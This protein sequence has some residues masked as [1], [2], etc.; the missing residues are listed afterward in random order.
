MADNIN[1]VF[2][3]IMNTV[4][5]IGDEIKT[6]DLLS[7]S[8]DL[9]FDRAWFDPG[10]KGVEGDPTSG[11]KEEVFKIDGGEVRI[12]DVP[13]D[14]L[15]RDGNLSLATVKNDETGAEERFLLTPDGTIL[16]DFDKAVLDGKNGIGG[17]GH[18]TEPV[19]IGEHIGDVFGENARGTFE[20]KLDEFARERK[21]GYTEDP[22]RTLDAVRPETGRHEFKSSDFDA[23]SPEQLE[24]EKQNTMSPRQ[25]ED[26]VVGKINE[27]K[28]YMTEKESKAVDGE[29]AGGLVKFPVD[30]DGRIKLGNYND[31]NLTDNGWRPDISTPYLNVKPVDFLSNG[32]VRTGKVDEK[33]QPIYRL[34]PAVQAISN[35]VIRKSAVETMGTAVENSVSA[36][37]DN[38]RSDYDKPTPASV[39]RSFE[40]R[41]DGVISTLNA[42][43]TDR[44]VALAGPGAKASDIEDFLSGARTP[45][46]G[47]GR[48]T[49][50]YAVYSEAVSP[51][52]EYRET[53]S[54]IAD[55]LEKC[56][57]ADIGSGPVTDEDGNLLPVSN[58]K[59]PAVI[60]SMLPEISSESM[61]G[62]REVFN[63]DG[64]ATALND[65]LEK[66]GEKMEAAGYH[67]TE[68]GVFVDEMG[69][70]PDFE[71]T[72]RERDENSPTGWNMD[73]VEEGK[74][75]ISKTCAARQAEIRSSGV[76]VST[77]T[78]YD[79]SDEAQ[80]QY[81]SAM[82]RGGR[83]QDPLAR[84]PSGDSGFV[85]FKNYEKAEKE[86]AGI[87]TDRASIEKA[88]GSYA[89]AVVR[90]VNGF[91]NAEPGVEP[92]VE[93]EGP[94]EG[95]RTGQNEY[96]AESGQPGSG[97]IDRHMDDADDGRRSY[98]YT[99]PDNVRSSKN[100]EG[101]LNFRAWKITA[102][103]HGISDAS[104]EALQNALDARNNVGGRLGF[105]GLHRYSPVFQISQLRAT[106]I[107]FANGVQINGHTM[108]ALDVFS[109]IHSI[110][111]LIN[112]IDN[113]IIMLGF[114]AILNFANFL[115]F[116]KDEN[117]VDVE[118]KGTETVR[119][120]AGN[121]GTVERTIVDGVVK[122]DD[123]TD[124]DGNPGWHREY[125]DDRS[126]VETKP[127]SDERM[128]AS[129]PDWHGDRTFR[130]YDKN[131][132]VVAEG[133]LDD[134]GRITEEDRYDPVSGKLTGTTRAVYNKDG[135]S[136]IEKTTIHP[137]GGKTVVEEIRS[138]HGRGKGYSLEIKTTDTSGKVSS[139]KFSVDEKGHKSRTENV[140]YDRDFPDKPST[141]EHYNDK[142]EI[143]G[144]T[145][146]EY[147][148][149]GNVVRTTNMKPNGEI[150]S[151][152]TKSVDRNTGD[153]TTTT[154]KFKDGKT[155]QT[156]ITVR[157]KDG[158]LMKSETVVNGV[159]VRETVPNPD[160]SDTLV[161]KDLNPD[162]SVSKETV[163]DLHGKELETR[164]TDSIGKTENCPDGVDRKIVSD[165]L[166]PD[167]IR[168]TKF[169]KE[170]DGTSFSVI[171]DQKN[172][173]VTL[174]RED[175]GGNP[176]KDRVF[177]NKT[178]MA[179]KDV[180]YGNDGSRVVTSFGRDG[181]TV[182][183]RENFRPDGSGILERFEKNG[184]VRTFEFSAPD[185][186]GNKV[187]TEDR[188]STIERY[189]VDRNGR[190][191]GM[192]T[193]DKATGRPLTSESYLRNGGKISNDYVNHTQTVTKT[194]KGGGTTVTVR[195]L[196]RNGK[197][198]AIF[199]T[200]ETNKAGIVLK[201]Q[202]NYRTGSYKG[203]PQ[204][205]I[206]RDAR[207]GSLTRMERY[208]NG[209][210]KGRL[211]TNRDGLTYNLFTRGQDGSLR[212]SA[213][214]THNG[215]GI[216]PDNIAG[217]IL[218]V[219]YQVGDTI[220]DIR[221]NED[222]VYR[223]D[224]NTG[225]REEMSLREFKAQH[226][227]E[228]NTG[229][230]ILRTA[231][232]TSSDEIRIEAGKRNSGK[233]SG[234][235][236]SGT[237]GASGGSTGN[238]GGPVSNDNAVKAVV[239]KIEAL[240]TD[241]KPEDIRNLDTALSDIHADLNALT[242]DQKALFADAKLSDGVT[243]AADR[244][245]AAEANKEKIDKGVVQAAVDKVKG[246]SGNVKPAD[247]R[248]L[249]SALSDIKKDYAD[250]TDDQKA[251]FDNTKVG[252]GLTAREKLN[253]AQANKDGIDYD[254]VKAL[255]DKVEALKAD[256]GP[257]DISRLDSALSEIRK[258]YDN[259]TDDQKAGF[260]REKLSDGSSAKD[261]IDAAQ[262]N[263]DKIDANAVKAVTDKVEGLGQGN[264]DAEKLKEIRADIEKLT[265]DQKSRLDTF[266][267]K[268]GSSVA[269]RIGREDRPEFVGKIEQAMEKYIAGKSDKDNRMD[270][271]TFGNIIGDEAK[272][273]KISGKT[274]A[275]KQGLVKDIGKTLAKIEKTALS[276]NSSKQAVDAVKTRIENVADVIGKRTG[277]G[278]KADIMKAVEA[279]RAEASVEA[280]EKNADV[281]TEK[282]EK[283]VVEEK[284][285]VTEDTSE[286]ADA[287]GT[288]VTED[289]SEKADAEGTPVT[290]DGPEE[291]VV[292]EA[293]VAGD[294]SEEA[295][296]GEEAPVTTDGPG[297]A[298]TEEADVTG[299]GF[300]KGEDRSED[301]SSRVIKESSGTE[302]YR[303][304]RL[305]DATR[306]YVNGEIRPEDFVSTIKNEL[307]GL[308]EKQGGV[309]AVGQ[310]IAKVENESS[311]K[312]NLTNSASDRLDD[313][314]NAVVS[315]LGIS[316]TDLNDAVRCGHLIEDMKVVHEEY[317]EDRIGR[318]EHDSRVER[319]AGAGGENRE[320]VVSRATAEE[321][322]AH[323]GEIE[324]GN[325]T[326]TDKIKDIVDTAKRIVSDVAGKIAKHGVE[327]GVGTGVAAVVLLGFPMEALGSPLEAVKTAASGMAAF[328]GV[329]GTAVTAGAAIVSMFPAVA[330]L[331]DIAQRIYARLENNGNQKVEAEKPNNLE[332]EKKDTKEDVESK[333]DEDTAVKEA[334]EGREIFSSGDN[335]EEEHERMEAGRKDGDNPETQATN[336]GRQDRPQDTEKQENGRVENQEN[337][338]T[339][340]PLENQ[341][342]EVED[343]TEDR[344]Q[345]VTS[346]GAE[347]AEQALETEAAHQDTVQEE[348]QDT[349]RQVET[350]T[351]TAEEMQGLTSEQTAEDT[352]GDE[353]AKVVEQSPDDA[354]KGEQDNLEAT[355]ADSRPEADPA[356]DTRSDPVVNNGET[357]QESA[358]GRVAE[359]NADEDA[360][361]AGEAEADDVAS[362]PLSKE[363]A[364]T[365]ASVTPPD[366]SEQASGDEAQKEGGKAGADEDDEKKE[367]EDTDSDTDL[368]QNDI[369]SLFDSV[370]GTLTDIIGD[371][372]NNCTAGDNTYSVSQAIEEAAIKTDDGTEKSLTEAL[373]ELSD[374]GIER[375]SVFNEA[376]DEVAKNGPPEGASEEDFKEGLATVADDTASALSTDTDPVTVGDRDYLEGAPQPEDVEGLG[377]QDSDPAAVEPMSDSTAANAH[378]LENTQDTGADVSLSR[379]EDAGFRDNMEN[380]GRIG[381]A[382]QVLNEGAGDASDDVAKRG[383]EAAAEKISPDAEK[384]L[385]VAELADNGAGDATDKALEMG[386]KAAAGAVGGPVAEV[387]ADVAFDALEK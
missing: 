303:P 104:K 299:D 315:V 15:D 60:L 95:G 347:N 158:N 337:E 213:V 8:E 386:A 123:Y 267:L 339:E 111:G 348:L 75:S 377:S 160:G 5:G 58:Q 345:D 23:K 116:E 198:G 340:K 97:G 335:R 70:S 354:E 216:D 146:Y 295:V 316:K 130:T 167:G 24:Y 26:I 239:D 271:K 317:I 28:P 376:L 249:D 179:K 326:I 41:V 17:L 236:G 65:I 208:E 189:T 185:A 192:E 10:Y 110:Y 286:K 371:A 300:E 244:L 325:K 39:V 372:V 178:G 38:G 353:V 201:E 16:Y 139:E 186:L 54:Q 230:S 364:N 283:T 237:G 18:G 187:Y 80:F 224:A 153:V 191:T 66:Y 243:P 86:R 124:A 74:D 282:S 103:P 133:R 172:N 163:V 29:L 143:S 144:V 154:V 105:S 136:R 323:S 367:R 232:G 51:L 147:D 48:F 382:A 96:P 83:R 242:A 384:A 150:E 50:A 301:I 338:N 180:D 365:A 49:G 252:G 85:S 227:D 248:S 9:I 73:M 168:T 296:D 67:M 344:I 206:E 149:D 281:G 108:T 195:E 265:P 251:R 203:T 270:R 13:D 99:G 194:I 297:E 383:L 308:K 235:T 332:N 100:G 220:V 277:L 261:K 81:E 233:G 260:D 343:R 321:I 12:T 217:S 358:S 77:T 310:A 46:C 369:E 14:D 349:V 117:R 59:D 331:L 106:C 313:I 241:A 318:N 78:P 378:D 262:A 360:A 127:G 162:G 3:Q 43:A 362:E 214:V 322:K 311:H 324:S 122:I 306:A 53:L 79:F 276:G 200:S 92:G 137:D 93:P 6:T 268:D 47:D 112:N 253:M 245:A 148:R 238:T 164:F 30:G 342:Q 64:S 193:I 131:D 57:T 42:A 126:Y 174:R 219:K 269:D 256:A 173:E 4:E 55:R 250:M 175:A 355:G 207:D 89:N 264:A 363:D 211:E 280:K 184:N 25:A 366:G 320:E 373:V 56:T 336:D 350:D 346:S 305:E 292:G 290:E 247:I 145:R 40:E 279:G 63:D 118:S 36:G 379:D 352:A 176:I 114:S 275:E 113:T 157:D 285:D 37:I 72:V 278:S 2:Q 291:A 44:L 171:K 287:E 387:V 132:N 115:V 82:A 257:E 11:I 155:D 223:Q 87:E 328:E 259:L 88:A 370:K 273:S 327:I 234:G 140:V 27:L 319:I 7:G 129:K 76:A 62:I 341:P 159:V 294:G 166:S 209:V 374:N 205:V 61:D 231:S 334:E 98:K 258:D 119:L 380:L 228:F 266:V 225:T 165:T 263:K 226:R 289:T 333:K 35:A 215:K 45:A 134:R 183:S 109:S 188:G 284:S 152:E 357:Y 274:E 34:S 330:P 210:I 361:D 298:V 204:S 141:V 314:K 307:G 161:I 170:P 177:D 19:Q 190:R 255:S 32:I 128:E 156:E 212:A 120:Y 138:A 52:I 351:A 222:K 121:G 302:L 196:D 304:V 199:D 368:S 246:L 182:V 69:V 91:E 22:Y 240:I 288:P 94:F 107:A 68:S 381:S 71:F 229:D 293:P 329:A 218:S 135:S 197:P 90:N 254:A 169:E 309:L 33:G 102:T 84:I 221:Y 181:K 359:R 101:N 142:G 202:H 375:Q 20:E 31:F 1:A 151:S 272:R 125:A 21:A 312:D 385:K 356:G